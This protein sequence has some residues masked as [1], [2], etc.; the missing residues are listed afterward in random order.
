M[1]G[2]DMISETDRLKRTSRLCIVDMIGWVLL[3]DH[4]LA[5][6]LLLLAPSE[7]AIANLANQ[8]RKE[9]AP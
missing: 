2:P 1:R 8:A 3:G 5:R 9:M 4:N 6:L 7:K